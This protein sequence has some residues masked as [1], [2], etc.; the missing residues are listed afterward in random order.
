MKPRRSGERTVLMQ[1][2]WMKSAAQGV[3]ESLLLRSPPT[4]SV[5]WRREPFDT[6][7]VFDLI[8]DIRDPEHP[9]SL[10]SWCLL[11]RIAFPLVLCQPIL[12]LV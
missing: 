4:V 9:L 2:A 1:R 8:R 3:N 11:S 7:E 12:L 6:Q 5:W 10:G